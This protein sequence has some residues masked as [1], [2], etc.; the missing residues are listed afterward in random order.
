MAFTPNNYTDKFNTN[1]ANQK[2][3]YNSYIKKNSKKNTNTTTI[4]KNSLKTNNIKNSKTLT[5]DQL[6]SF[7]NETIEKINGGFEKSWDES[8][9]KEAA[10]KIKIKLKKYDWIPALEEWL[11]FSIGSL[12]NNDDTINEALLIL[13]DWA[14]FKTG[15]NTYQSTKYTAYKDRECND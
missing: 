4:N 6:I 5:V 3:A 7:A 10:D 13:M 2:Y 11:R 15:V 9:T 8:F 12:G 14:F 1:D